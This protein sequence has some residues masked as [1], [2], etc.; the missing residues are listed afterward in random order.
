MKIYCMHCK[1][2]LTKRDDIIEVEVGVGFMHDSCYHKW[3]ET[4]HRKRIISYS[5]AVSKVKKLMKVGV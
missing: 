1:E 5:K 4:Q 3:L 2:E